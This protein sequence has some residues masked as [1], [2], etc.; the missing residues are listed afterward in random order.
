MIE[1]VDY[2]AWALDLC[3]LLD[4]VEMRNE[5]EGIDTLLKYR[6]EIAENRGFKVEFLGTVEIGHA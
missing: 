2:K 1:N 5:D 3:S 6:F 4:E